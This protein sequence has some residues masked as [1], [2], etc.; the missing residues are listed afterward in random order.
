[1]AVGAGGDAGQGHELPPAE[2]G[3]AG[4]EFFSHRAIVFLGVKGAVL[5]DGV[6]QEQIEDGARRMAELAV[7]VDGGASAGLIAVANGVL[8]GTEQGV[9]LAGLDLGTGVFAGIGLPVEEV[10]A[11]VGAVAGGLEPSD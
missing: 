2:G 6:A 1:M 4:G 9:W 11:A 7:A 10:A 3:A 8:G 5:A